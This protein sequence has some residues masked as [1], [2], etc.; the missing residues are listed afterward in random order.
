MKQVNESAAKLQRKKSAAQEVFIPGLSKRPRKTTA[1]RDLDEESN[2]FNSCLVPSNV[3]EQRDKFMLYGLTPRFK[4]P[5]GFEPLYNASK[6][7]TYQIRT[8]LFNEAKAI[9]DKVCSVHGNSF[10]YVEN[11]FGKQINQEDAN[12]FI[13]KYIKAHDLDGC[14]TVYWSPSIIAR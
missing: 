13:Q 11:T 5:R 4:Y 12:T 7:E 1:F 10:G 6:L 9:I 8:N 14:M 2:K 3:K